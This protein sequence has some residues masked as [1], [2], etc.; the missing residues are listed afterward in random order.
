MDRLLSSVR[1]GAHAQQLSAVVLGIGNTLLCD[2]GAGVHVLAALGTRD[3]SSGM[4]LV[5][6]GTLN[7]ALLT[8]LE[9]AAALIVVDAGNLMASPGTVSSFE[10]EAM[11]SFLARTDRRR[12]VHEVGL[13]DLLAIALLRE[14]LPARRAL[15]C[16]QPARVDWGLTVTPAVEPAVDRAADEVLRILRRWRA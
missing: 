7:F 9:D 15:V 13:L 1:G 14:T 12:T 2:E 5:D 4:T 3:E 8:H 11:D 10:G 6:G 16:I